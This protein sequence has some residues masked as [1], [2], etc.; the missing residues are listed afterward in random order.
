MKRNLK[1]VLTLVLATVML[2]TCFAGCG[3]SGSESGD[4]PKSPYEITFVYPGDPADD[5]DVVLNEFYAQTKDT[6]NVTLSFIY[7]GWDDIG[8]KV[9]L[10]IS[11]GK[12]MDSAFLA[13]WAEI[14]DFHF[15]YP[16]CEKHGWRSL[17]DSGYAC[18]SGI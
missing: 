13:Q 1:K 7:A 12:K 10:K 16:N 4:G 8:Q 6:L 17:P 18:H 11:G 14:S 15:P 9:S 3:K 2:L 5:M